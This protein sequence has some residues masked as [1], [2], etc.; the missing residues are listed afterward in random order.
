M[1]NFEINFILF[2]LANW[3]NLEMKEIQIV[4]KLYIPYIYA[5]VEIRVDGNIGLLRYFG[6]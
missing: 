3:K 4:H 6:A 1:Q 2:I 5:L